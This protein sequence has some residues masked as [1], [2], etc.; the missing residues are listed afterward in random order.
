ML[1]PESAARAVE[2]DISAPGARTRV[3]MVPTNEELLIARDTAEV[4]RALR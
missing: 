1:L 3:R 4:I 2:A